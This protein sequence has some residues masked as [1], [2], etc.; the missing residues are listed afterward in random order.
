MGSLLTSTMNTRALPTGDFRFIR[1]DC[2]FRLTDDEVSWL[3]KNGITTVV[4][5]REEQEYSIKPCCLESEPGFVYY[6]LP[7]TG[8]G[9]TPLSPEAVAGVYLG[10]LDSRMDEIIRTITE[11]DSNVIY[12][13]TA[14][15]DRTGV[16]SAVL[17]RRL[18]FT[19]DVIIAD[20]MATKE[21]L[22]SF[23]LA[24]VSE[25]PEVDIGTIMPN[26]NNIKRVLEKL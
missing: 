13:C 1:S 16:V 3:R 21:N 26:E 11:A 6:H 24:Y 20:Y 7:V 4:D 12:F 22:Q 23:L 25:H 18:G 2:P 14:G 10:M 19:D 17:L 8:G 5:L 15:K 9:G